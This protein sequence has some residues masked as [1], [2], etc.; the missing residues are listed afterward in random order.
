MD[1]QMDYP[2][3]DLGCPFTPRG[4]G[5]ART[6]RFRFAPHSVRLFNQV[7]QPT[8][9]SEVGKTASPSRLTSEQK[10]KLKSLS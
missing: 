9:L 4:I 10:E 6:D 8:L 2:I 7:K 3:L 1:H 5:N